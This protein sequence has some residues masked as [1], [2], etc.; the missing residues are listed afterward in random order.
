M[1]LKSLFLASLAALAMVSCSNEDDQ[2][3]DGTNGGNALMQFAISAPTTRTTNAS[4]ALAE[5]GTTAENGFE[6]IVIVLKYSNN[7]Q[8][9]LNLAKEKFTK[10]GQMLYMTTPEIVPAGSATAYVFVNGTES[11]ESTDYT[12]LTYEATYTNSYDILAIA[13]SGKFLMTNS[14]SIP[15]LDF[16]EGQ[17]TSASIPVDRVVAKIEEKSSTEPISVTVNATDVD[18]NP[19]DYQGKALSIKLENYAYTDLNQK[20]NLLTTGTV[21]DALF[22]PFATTNSYIYKTVGTQDT[23]CLE[24]P[25]TVSIIYKA[26]AYWDGAEATKSFYTVNGKL[27]ID[28]AELLKEYKALP[29]DDNGTIEEFYSIGI[30]KFENGYCY[31]V[32]EIENASGSKN[33]VRNNIYRLNVSTISNLGTTIPGGHGDDKRAFLKL[34]VEINKWTINLNSFEF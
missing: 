19:V 27:Y 12:K 1:K 31:Y 13:Q 30:N 23:Y 24:N 14:K 21:S 20:T 18:G 32:A 33:I 22:Q 11:S 34:N 26:K 2:I 17:T 29:Y 5:E 9:V 10:E 25:N 28:Y 4:G 16:T 8:R 3:I 7:V 6:N 15:T